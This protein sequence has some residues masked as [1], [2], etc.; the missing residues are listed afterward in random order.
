MK[1]D[2]NSS[3]FHSKGFLEPL[4]KYVF[5]MLNMLTQRP[6]PKLSYPLRSAKKLSKPDPEVLTSCTFF[7]NGRGL[8]IFLQ[9]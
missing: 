2:I 1:S 5:D 3:L 7:T 9:D 6:A 4:H 8:K